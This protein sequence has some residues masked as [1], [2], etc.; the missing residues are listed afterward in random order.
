MHVVV[1]WSRKAPISSTGR[2]DT[3]CVKKTVVKTQWSW[4]TTEIKYTYCRNTKTHNRS[5]KSVLNAMA[6]YKE[7]YQRKQS[8]STD[9][10]CRSREVAGFMANNLILT[11]YLLHYSV[12]QGV[13]YK[14]TPQLTQHVDSFCGW[15]FSR[16]ADYCK[17]VQYKTTV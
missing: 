11:V 8:N 15:M 1:C 16:S 13:L 2:K 4:N 5:N 17:C 10:M 3:L 14:R 6:I 9:A 12:G 7:L